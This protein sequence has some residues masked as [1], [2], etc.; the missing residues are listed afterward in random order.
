MRRRRRSRINVSTIRGKRWVRSLPGAAVEPHARSFLAGN[1]RNPSC[2]IS[3]SQS[4]L[5]GS[6]SVLIGRHGAINPAGKVRCNMQT[7]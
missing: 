3:C 6:L 4:R 2:L 1:N 7:E 5:E